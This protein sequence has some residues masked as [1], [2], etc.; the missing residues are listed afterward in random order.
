ME[1][2]PYVS[3]PIYLKA[4]EELYE[5][6]M[7]YNVTIKEIKIMYNGFRI[8]FDEYPEGDIICHDYSYNHQNGLWESFGFPWDE[9]DVTTQ[10]AQ[11]FCAKLAAYHYYATKEY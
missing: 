3:N 7:E 9:D 2:R 1:E 5:W 11:E 8:I 4:L 10:T 6:A